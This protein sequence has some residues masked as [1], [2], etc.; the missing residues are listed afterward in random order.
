MTRP[1]Y[2][3]RGRSTGTEPD[4]YSMGPEP[5][6]EPEP[7]PAD[8]RLDKQIQHVLDQAIDG[9]PPTLDDLAKEVAEERQAVRPMADIWWRGELITVHTDEPATAVFW[10]LTALEDTRVD[11]ILTAMP[12]KLLDAHGNVLWPLKPVEPT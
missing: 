2:K 4:K 12:M 5:E 11:A 3:S 9:K 7:T 8:P 10:C 1:D 6:P